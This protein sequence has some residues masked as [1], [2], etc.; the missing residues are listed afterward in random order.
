MA[1]TSSSVM[2]AATWSVW[3]FCS[4]TRA[5]ARSLISAERL[6]SF[7]RWREPALICDSSS[8]VLSARMSIERESAPNSQRVG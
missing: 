4:C 3:L 2:A 6:A 5:I 1:L 8:P 7:T